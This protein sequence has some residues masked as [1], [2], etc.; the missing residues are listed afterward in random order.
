MD[1]QTAKSLF[2]A[3]YSATGKGRATRYGAGAYTFG[4]VRNPDGSRQIDTSIIYALTKAEAF[5]YRKEYRRAIRDGALKVHELSDYMA[6]LADD[7]KK[8]EAAAKAAEAEAKK[9]A[10]AAKKANKKA[11]DD[12]ADKE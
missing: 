3:F 7:K 11:A 8:A 9:A 6:Y 2:G 12:A 10:A 4:E 1:L 5:R